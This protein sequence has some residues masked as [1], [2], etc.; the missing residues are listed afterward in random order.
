MSYIVNFKPYKEDNINFEYYANIEQ[1]VSAGQS[2]SQ[3]EAENYMRLLAYITR[4]KINQE[5]DNFDFKCDLAQ[6]MIGHYLDEINC[7]YSPC[8]TQRAISDKATGHNFTTIFLNVEG[9]EKRYL[10]DP[11]YIQFFHTER[12]L[13]TN[14]LV[15]DLFP[16]KILLTPD[17]GFFIRIEDKEPAEFLLTNGYIELTPDYARMYGDSFLNTICGKNPKYLKYESIPGDIYCNAF[18]KGRETLS[19]TKEELELNSQRIVTFAE[20]KNNSYGK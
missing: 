9:E 14:F 13:N 17:P 6:S 20:Q 8:S 5:M 12:C 19:K 1:K 18:T 15:S 3:N 11:T 4:K 16:D 2:I 7:R 10:F